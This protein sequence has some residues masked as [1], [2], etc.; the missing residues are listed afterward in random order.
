MPAKRPTATMIGVS[1]GDRKEKWEWDS[2][3]IFH[4]SHT[5]AGMSAYKKAP[6]ET[7]VEVANETILPVDASGQLRWTWTSRVP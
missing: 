6:A 3:A 5:Q 2:G 1:R 7:T 4:M